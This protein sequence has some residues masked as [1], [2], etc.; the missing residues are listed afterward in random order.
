MTR[1]DFDFENLSRLSNFSLII[2]RSLE[3]LNLQTHS[4]FHLLA[5]PNG[6]NEYYSSRKHT[7]F[8]LANVPPDLTPESI[9]RYIRGHY[10][11]CGHLFAEMQ[12]IYDKT[13]I[14]IICKKVHFPRISTIFSQMKTKFTNF[15]VYGISEVLWMDLI[16]SYDDILQYEIERL[17][18]APIDLFYKLQ[19]S[20]SRH[21]MNSVSYVYCDSTKYLLQGK[22]STYFLKRSIYWKY[23]ELE[24]LCSLDSW[25]YHSP[26]DDITTYTTFELLM[27]FFITRFIDSKSK[28]ANERIFQIHINVLL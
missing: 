10:K 11:S 19:L 28:R 7:R 4:I 9:M 23:L 12:Q 26:Y 21:K 18:Q 2:N 25:F 17:K 6:N 3:T 27:F 22:Y 20:K 13:F 24:R 14:E 1:G 5:T 15:D 8:I 16:K